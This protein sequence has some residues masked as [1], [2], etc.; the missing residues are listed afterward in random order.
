MVILKVTTTADSGVGSLRDAVNQAQS[1]DEIRFNLPS[2]SKITLTSGEITIP[3]AKNLIIDGIGITNLTISGNKA[4]RIFNLQSTTATVTQLTLKNLNLIDGVAPPE[5]AN[6]DGSTPDISQRG[7]AILSGAGS[8][9]TVDQVTFNDN[10]GSRGGGAIYST[11]YSK[12]TVLNSTFNRNSGQGQNEERAGGAITFR[13]PNELIVKNSTFKDN[14]GVNGGAI[15]IVHGKLTIDNSSFINNTS[16]GVY[17]PTQTSS[18]HGDPQT[19][20]G[21]VRGYGGAVYV[22][23]AHESA[24]PNETGYVRIYRSVF[25]GN[26]GKGSGGAAYIYTVP[27]DKVIIDSSSFNNNQ[28]TALTLKPGATPNNV[29]KN[30]AQGL[31]GAVTQISNAAIGA[32]DGFS[33]TNSTFANNKATS[34]GGGL[35]QNV[36]ETSIVNSTFFGNKAKNPSDPTL[37][38]VIGGGL[39]LFGP[40]T[41]SNTTIANNF[42]GSGGGGLAVNSQSQSSTNVTI[43]N[44]IFNKNS[45]KVENQF[46]NTGSHTNRMIPNGQNNIQSVS[47]DDLAVEG[48]QVIDPKLDVL[49]DNGGPTN[50]M[51][52]L[53]GSPAIDAGANIGNQVRDQRGNS[54]PADGDGKNGARRDIGAFEVSNGTGSPEIEV[55]LGGV[56]LSDGSVIP[57]DYGQTKVATPINKT[58]IIRNTGTTNLSLEGLQLPTGFSL[59]GS[60]PSSVAPNSQASINIQLISPKELI[61]N[62]KSGHFG[63]EVLLATNDNNENPFSFAIKGSVTTQ[64][65]GTAASESLKGSKQDSND[66]ERGAEIDEII[67]AMDGN[68]T[69]SAE[70]GDDTVNGG[71]GNDEIDAGVG[72]NSLAGGAGN[73]NY[74]LRNILDV[75]KENPGSDID[76]VYIAAD[77]T[78]GANLENLR[79][80]GTNDNKGT[81]NSLKNLLTGNNGNNLL[82]GLSGDDNLRGGE[83]DDS[84]TGGE[85]ND[86][87]DLEVN[88]TKEY[89]SGNDTLDGG[90]GND[91]YQ[92]DSGEDLIIETSSLATEIDR[93]ISAS[94][95]TLGNNVEFLSL[96]SGMAGG[97][98]IAATGNQLNNSLLGN[99]FNNILTGSQGNDTLNGSIG[100]DTLRGGVGNDTYIITDKSDLIQEDSNNPT[101]IDT[102][103]STADYSLGVNNVENLT[104]ISINKLG[105]G[106]TGRGNNLN[107]KIIGNEWD[108]TLSGGTG[109]DSLE[110]GA[111]NDSLEGGA[112][113]D[114]LNPGEGSDMLDGGTGSDIYYVD[115]EGDVVKE[116]STMGEIDEV[117]SSLSYHLGA[118]LDSLTLT[119]TDNIDGNGNE[120]DNLV[121]GNPGINILTG[122]EG[123][124][125]L[126]GREGNDTLVGGAGNDNLTG[127][128]GAD[129]FKFFYPSEK[130]DRITDFEPLID[131][132][133]VSTSGFGGISLGALEESRFVVGSK[134]TEAKAQ[135]IYDKD[136]GNL[137]FDSDGTGPKNPENFASVTNKASITSNHIKVVNAEMAMSYRASVSK[138]GV[139]E[140]ALGQTTP[141]KFIINRRGV[142]STSS[143]IEYMLAGTAARGFDYQA[144]SFTGNGVNTTDNTINFAPGATVATLNL[145][146]IGDL[147]YE[148]DEAISINLLNPNS[149]DSTIPINMA[150][151]MINNDDSRPQISASDRSIT[152]GNGTKNLTFTVNLSNR[153]SNIVSVNYMTADETALGGSDYTG[154]TGT[155][156][157]QAFQ[158]SNTITVPVLGDMEVENDETFL[159]KLSDANGATISTPVITGLIKN[160]DRRPILYSIYAEATTLAEGNP[161]N[162]VAK[163]FVVTRSNF[164]GVESSI[165]YTLGGIA[166]LDDDYHLLDP[167]KQRVHTTS[168]TL[169]FASG[170]SSVTL[171]FKSVGDLTFE[172]DEN[173]TVTL[174]NPNPVTGRIPKS[175]ASTTIINDDSYPII[176]SNNLTF[177]ENIDGNLVNFIVKLANPSYHAISVDFN[178]FDGTALADKDYT[179]TSGTLTFAPGEM[180]KSLSVKVIDDINIEA[181]E[182]FSVIFSNPTNADLGTTT[183]TGVIKNDDKIKPIDYAIV[184]KTASIVEGNSP[185]ITPVSF[186][187]SR[188]K[189]TGTTSSIRYG[190][191]GSVAAENSDFKQGGVT[192][193]NVSSGNGRI[194]FATGAS[195]ATLTLNVTGDSIYE[196]NEN[197]T[198]TLSGSDTTGATITKPRA[199]TVILNDDVTLVGTSGADS[200]VAGAENNTLIGGGGADTLIGGGGA[201]TLTGGQGNDQYV[202]NLLSDKGDT[203]TDFRVGQDK[204]NLNGLL[205]SL[206]YKGTNPI[207]DGYVTFV[208]G[209]PTS[210]TN[211]RID[212]DGST[213]SA[214]P[215]SYIAFQNVSINDL[216]KVTNFVF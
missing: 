213:G 148:S 51:A 63:G 153:S 15:N 90:I 17:D 166:T 165:D 82:T 134:A 200:L 151:A 71:N 127:G 43:N 172:P 36:S 104:L 78:L 80:L 124:D 206:G 68:D 146:V 207:T 173:F 183:V 193:T 101:E 212:S 28:V 98:G 119:G 140:G 209:T 70:A 32:N 107:N 126:T 54:R 118:N 75:V 135:F 196:L 52:L 147:T 103:S 125:T 201:D 152:E 27:K 133:M 199:T 93:I 48:I 18:N 130:R 50:T 117:R 121:V 20:S 42:A 144:D 114:S 163:N 136:T 47:T 105:M 37:T 8:T 208:I 9:L 112:G 62:L 65:N 96:T 72:L 143:S 176:S 202:Y 150:I 174:S 122:R 57:Y 79:L 115:D 120:K 131:N 10:K 66:K 25:E 154:I 132:I 214:A 157:F 162:L 38:S 190:F 13:G 14:K 156:T 81:G 203:I 74:T 89:G 102:V 158:T 44:T 129:S 181:D 2:G 92:V 69:I 4:S 95:Y 177:S 189:F 59:E 139:M 56:S 186:V 106:S 178:T 142:T 84:L 19:D 77:Y 94:N 87:F 164:T 61:D 111:G 137:F 179:A 41:L 11:S 7:G 3:E 46:T 5:P 22:D 30:L 24:I 100:E 97:S 23:S 149:P 6:S 210:M 159:V 76:G 39:A 128:A 197:L 185:K 192:G 64:I 99:E 169:T 26:K 86:S 198:V 184:A 35:W 113:N 55:I 21:R 116:T 67:N 160:D 204:I 205:S 110:G 171:T 73:D 33:L 40:V 1:G 83:G 141:I 167:N 180:T 91:T 182:N 161:P 85:G 188:S 60:L 191:S 170:V 109:N 216:N 168:N 12:L 187:I 145:N 45:V 31:G 49:K 194:T 195:L 155:L 58:L 175:A 29:S 108:N 215:L 16:D 53:P 88:N 138:L 123:N 211:I 34:Q